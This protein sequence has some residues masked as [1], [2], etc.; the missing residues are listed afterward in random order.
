MKVTKTELVTEAVMRPR[1][2]VFLAGIRSFSAKAWGT[3]HRAIAPLTISLCVLGAG[4]QKAAAQAQVTGQWVTL[5]YLMPI[6]PIHANLLRNGKVLI[7]A[8][9]ENNPNKHLQGSSKAAVWI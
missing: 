6:N 4:S 8:G 7:V 1:A 9:S 2:R 5:P 3:I